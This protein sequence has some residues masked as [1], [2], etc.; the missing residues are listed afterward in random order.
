MT[1]VDDKELERR[2]VLIETDVDREMA[3][4][5]RDLRWATVASV[6]I[7]VPLYILYLLWV[8]VGIW[9]GIGA[10]GLIMASNVT[11]RILYRRIDR[12]Y[13]LR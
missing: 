9:T 7:T 2:L 6:A 13:K 3:P 12:K 10:F 11:R 4:F 8:P 1:K 5:K